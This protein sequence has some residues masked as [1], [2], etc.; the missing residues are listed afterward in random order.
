M[1]QLRDTIIR[2]RAAQEALT[3]AQ[4]VCAAAA[5]QYHE[6]LCGEAAV[7]AVREAAWAA[8]EREWQRSHADD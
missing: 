4:D 2:R 5:V 7:E 1:S 8:E 3:L 6:A